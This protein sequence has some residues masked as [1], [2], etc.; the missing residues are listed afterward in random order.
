MITTEQI[1]NSIHLEEELLGILK[2][3][4]LSKLMDFPN[5]KIHICRHDA[6]ENSLLSSFFYLALS[7][8]C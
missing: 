8:N 5:K 6:P 4:S 3:E 1:D 2:E 7:T